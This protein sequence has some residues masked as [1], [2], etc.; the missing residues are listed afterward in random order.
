[1]PRVVSLLA[2]ALAA[3]LLG[4]P[5]A[6]EGQARAPRAWR[7]GLLLPRAEPAMEAG[8]RQGLRDLG[9]VE[10]Q[11]VTIDARSTGGAPDRTAAVVAEF[12]RLPVDVIVTWTTPAALAATRGTYRIPVVAVTGDPVTNGLVAGLARPGGNFTGITILTDEL[13]T[14]ALELLR[15]AIPQAARLA[16][17]WNPGNP[18]WPPVLKRLQDTATAL[19]VKLHPVEIGDANALERGFAAAIRQQANAVLVLRDNLFAVNSGRIVDLAA[20]H[21]LPV[22]YGR[23]TDVEAGG[24]M[25]Y[26]VDLPGLMRRLATYVDKILKGATPADL[27][28]EQPTR[29]ELVI[30]LKTAKSLGLTIPQSVLQRADEVIQ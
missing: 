7:I 30:N 19:G 26:G 24:L 15:E 1:M 16:V 18:L 12:A 22:M 14:K 9:Y 4:A 6:S 25:S 27:P 8:F 23:R 17:F 11:H 3:A 20:R 10:G 2:V 21:R 13:D 5:P 28:V 29:F